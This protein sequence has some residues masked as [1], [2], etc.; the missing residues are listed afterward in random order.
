MYWDPGPS[1]RFLHKGWSKF[2]YH[3][4]SFESPLDSKKIKPINPKG[5]QSWISRTDA[6]AEAPIPWPPDVKSQLIGKDPDAVNEGR[7]RRRWQRMRWLDGITDSMDVN[8]GK[9]WEMMRDRE[10]RHAVVH[11]VAKTRTQLS[12]W[13]TIK[14]VDLINTDM[15][16]ETSI[17]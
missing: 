13:T 3:Q 12:E 6:E 17:L 15:S 4:I 5:N 8:L 16:L 9:F 11:E 14:L 1:V 2:E 10:A 7:R